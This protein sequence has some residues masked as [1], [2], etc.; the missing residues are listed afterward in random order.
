MSFGAR[1]ATAVVLVA[2]AIGFCLAAPYLGSEA[3]PKLLICAAVCAVA[4]TC[5]FPGKHA[6]VTNRIIGGVVFFIYVEYLVAEIRERHWF[7]WSRSTPCV[8]NALLGLL[9][10]GL[11]AAYVMVRGHLW[12]NPFEKPRELTEE[13]LAGLESDDDDDG[14]YDLR[15]R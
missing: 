1:L 4:T 9:F 14:D 13:E 5:C 2:C 3:R 11:P 6:P 10:W 7:S 12:Y 15:Q 8:K